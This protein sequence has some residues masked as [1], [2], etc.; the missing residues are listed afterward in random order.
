MGRV[1]WRCGV[2]RRDP[3]MYRV[4]YDPSGWRQAA[5]W[6]SEHVQYALL[7]LGPTRQLDVELV[8]LPNGPQVA[9]AEVQE[10]RANQ[11]GIACWQRIARICRA[12]IV[13]VASPRAD[14]PHHATPCLAATPVDDDRL[15]MTNGAG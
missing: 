6:S 5:P 10:W 8:L 7:P 15:A 13:L 3:L 4:P 9:A 12:D 2:G 14:R 1:R 11:H